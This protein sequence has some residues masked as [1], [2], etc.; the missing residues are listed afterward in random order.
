MSEK[1]AIKDFVKKLKSYFDVESFGTP[2]ER[3]RPE[4]EFYKMI[5]RAVEE[6]ERKKR[7]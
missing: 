3:W 6:T 2:D 4:S 7:K 5:D 1:K